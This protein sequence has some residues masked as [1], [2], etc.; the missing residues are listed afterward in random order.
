MKEKV[1]E[2]QAKLIDAFQ[3]SGGESLAALSYIPLLGWVYPYFFRK[4]E[5]LVRFH[6]SQAMQLNAMITAIYFLIWV[7]EYFPLTGIFF[8][9]GSLLHPISRTLWLFTVFAYM[10]F[11]LVASY[12]AYSGKKWE[13]PYLKE[14]VAKILDYIKSLRKRS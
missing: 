14:R 13:I 8:G 5:E 11:S 3:K 7:L 6:A 1:K 4:E 10:A 12:Q 9:P 2:I